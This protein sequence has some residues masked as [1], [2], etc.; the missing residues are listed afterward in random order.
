MTSTDPRNPLSG[1]I[2][3]E[4]AA[5]AAK[6]AARANGN[7]ELIRVRELADFDLGEER[8]DV[9]G[10]QV[11]SHDA[12]LV[13]LVDALFVDM[14]TRAVRYLGVSLT[15]SRTN[16]PTGMVLAPI[17]AASRPGDR[18]VVVL[19]ALSATQLA[20]APRIRN[21]PVTRAD[22]NATLAAYGMATSRD[23]PSGQLYSGPN[24]DER[25]LFARADS[26]DRS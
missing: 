20:G 19:N 8:V 13:G 22:E 15:D 14:R 3:V 17:G 24:F 18:R 5:Q 4:A 7:S 26:R 25:R 16:L 2:A 21:R 9:R 11:Y 1:D 10:W 23:V 6:A 12:Q